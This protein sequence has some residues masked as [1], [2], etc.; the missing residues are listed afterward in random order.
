MIFVI[1]AVVI[2]RNNTVYIYIFN[3]L[4]SFQYITEKEAQNE[5]NI[6][7]RRQITTVSAQK[8]TT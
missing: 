2:L 3:A 7:K 5:M 6:E 8:L 1:L 4:D